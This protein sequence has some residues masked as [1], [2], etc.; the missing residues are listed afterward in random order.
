MDDAE[1]K[2]LKK[3]GKSLVEKRSAELRQQ[4]ARSNSATFGSDEYIRNEIEIR[5]KEQKV[6]LEDRAISKA[7][8]ECNFITRPQ[9]FDLCQPYLEIQ[10]HFWQCKNCGDYI[11]MATAHRLK[12]S[13]GNILLDGSDRVFAVDDEGLLRLVRV[14]GKISASLKKES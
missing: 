14:L 13:C 2:R 9:D 3:F 11:P 8:M 10:G 4:L 6:R 5:Q 1:K 7:E 12:C